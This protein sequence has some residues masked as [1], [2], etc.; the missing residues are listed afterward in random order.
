VLLGQGFAMGYDPNAAIMPAEVRRSFLG[1]IEEVIAD[2]AGR[3][4]DHAAFIDR[5]CKA[6][7]LAA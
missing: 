5:Y 7:P 2:A 4:P 1:D 6:P 3:M